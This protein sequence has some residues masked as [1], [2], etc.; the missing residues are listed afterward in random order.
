MTQ[1]TFWM[2][3][4]ETEDELA[5]RI[6]VFPAIS[7]EE[8]TGAMRSLKDAKNYLRGQRGTGDCKAAIARNQ[9]INLMNDAEFVLVGAYAKQGL[10][11]V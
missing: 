10:Q 9:A 3:A 8:F 7:Y 2:T 5:R 1:S 4:Q 6:V 11:A